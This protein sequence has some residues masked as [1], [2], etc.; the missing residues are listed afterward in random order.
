[1]SAARRVTR[2]EGGVTT[3]SGFLAAATAAGIKK[4]AGA[5]DMALV[6][7]E[8]EC[9]AAGVFTTNRVKA[10][11]VRDAMAKLK[12]EPRIRGVL[13]NSGSANA[14]TGPAGM[15]DLRAIVR[16]L[17]AG[18]GV[19]PER[20]LM[21]STGV[22]GERIPME[23]ALAGATMLAD[24]LSAGAGHQ[25]A[26]AIMTTDTYPKECAVTV[27]TSRGPVTI[28]GMA[29]GAG[30]INPQMAT[31]LAF[32]TTD[33]KL[34]DAA[35]LRS[36]LRT[37]VEETLNR[38]DLDTDTSTND[39]VIL[40]AGGKS[41]I[42]PQG[43]DLE[44][45][46]RGLALVCEDLA[47]KIAGDTEGASKVITISVTGARSEREAALAARA[48]AESPLVKTAFHGRDP[49]WGR[50]MAALGRSGAKFKE[51]AV[52]IAYN[53]LLMVSRGVRAEGVTEEA[54]RAALAPRD[55][56]LD[57]CLGGGPAGY[58]LKT[59]DLTADYVSI[60]ASYRS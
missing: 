6:V 51:S 32:I 13:V 20:V 14:C 19:G 36:L 43:D 27:E 42:T 8:G 3:P 38:I 9:V 29:K 10:A 4:K 34:E 60:N 53:G 56:A 12:K 11:P 46:A 5:L 55:I 50:I 35:L 47:S 18:L 58:R 22:I 16:R 28:G 45:F 40:L 39:C 24:G 30:M 1:M 26:L 25:A 48:V 52:E 41:G 37:A 21:A 31:M 59:G 54:A 7:G 33:A 23:K 44:A 57:I 15:A 17:A 2:I 49:N